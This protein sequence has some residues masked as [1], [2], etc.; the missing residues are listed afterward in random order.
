MRC[1][2]VDDPELGT[3][4]PATTD[5]PRQHRGADRSGHRAGRPLGQAVLHHARE[6]SQRTWRSLAPADG[7]VPFLAAGPQSSERLRGIARRR[8]DYVDVFGAEGGVGETRVDRLCRKGD[9]ELTP[10]QA[11]FVDGE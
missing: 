1:V 4:K 8:R 5:L 6:T 3:G 2:V 11:L 10:A 7:V 9:L